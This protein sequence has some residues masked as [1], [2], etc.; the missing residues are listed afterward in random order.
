MLNYDDAPIIAC[1]SGNTKCAI[2]VIRISGFDFLKNINKFFN[3]DLENLD[4][5]SA[6]FSKIISKESIIDEVVVTYFKGPKSYNG[7]DI[8]EIG[9]HGNPINVQRIIDLLKSTS[10]IRDANPGEFSLRA[11]QNGKLNLNQVEGLDLM[12][13]ADSVFSLDQGLSLLGGNL[14]SLFK[15]LYDCYLTHRSDL[16]LGFDFLEDIGEDQFNHKFQK[17]L[18]D[19]K[20]VIDKLHTHI[21]NSSHQLLKPEIALVGLPNAGKSSLFNKI[22]RSDRSIV[23]KV[24]GTTRDFISENISIDNNIFKLVDTAGIRNTSD[25]VEAEGVERSLEI[26]GNAFFKILLV[27]PKSFEK[28]FYNQIKNISFDLILFSH[29]D[30][31]NFKDY[32]KSNGSRILSALGP[33]EPLDLGPIEPLDLGP[34]EPLDFGPIEPL[35]FGPIEPADFG[36]I[37]PLVERCFKA[38][39]LNIDSNALGLIEQKINDK[40]LKLLNFDPILINRHKITIKNIHEK[41]I[42]YELLANNPNGDIS[43]IGSEL[44][45]VGHCISE[46]IGIVSPD[47]VL[48]NIFDNFCIGK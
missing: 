13:N 44:N 22:L 42:Q 26:L 21:K 19:L 11:L 28:E 32:F 48:H 8:L 29:A 38:N 7:E 2:S 6:N 39:I 16:E 9:A 1:S 27:N 24:E 17:S 23:S 34:I 45:I 20:V 25:T 36:P 4:P 3:L 35:D 14:N 15:S 46:L 12:L 18:S 31:V 33:I 41:F 47:D 40:Y 43:I 10:N 30:E 37:E 5:C